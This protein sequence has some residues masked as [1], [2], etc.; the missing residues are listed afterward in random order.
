MAP[1]LIDRARHGWWSVLVAPLPLV[2][3][4]ILWVTM[5]TPPDTVRRTVSIIVGGIAGALIL[6]AATEML[7]HP[8]SAQPSSNGN[9]ELLM[10]QSSSQPPSITQGPGS[11]TTFGQSGGSNVIYN[12][13]RLAEIGPD[14]IPFIKTKIPEGSKI[15]ILKNSNDSPS[16]EMEQRLAKLLM[17]NG[18]NVAGSGIGIGGQYFKGISVGDTPG[19]EDMY[20]ITIGDPRAD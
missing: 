2:V 13:P 18:Y 1:S 14:A 9:R 10:T 19:V 12:G 20:T 8:A 5:S 4:N 11:I 16:A 6:L 17:D 3:W 7:K 15:L